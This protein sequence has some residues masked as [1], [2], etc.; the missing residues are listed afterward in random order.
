M[1]KTPKTN[2]A[3]GTSS[4][5]T[6]V[7]K[8]APPQKGSRSANAA[9]LVKAKA[10]IIDA[11]IALNLPKDQVDKVEAHCD[12]M[13]A[14]SDFALL[15]EA[16]A[17]E[18]ATAAKDSDSLTGVFKHILN[19]N[20]SDPAA[21]FD[22]DKANILAVAHALTDDTFSIQEITRM[23]DKKPV[24][25]HGI[26]MAL[27]EAEAIIRD[28]K[29]S[30]EVKIEAQKTL[31]S[32]LDFIRPKNSIM[33]IDVPCPPCFMQKSNLYIDGINA[34]LAKLTQDPEFWWQPVTNASAAELGQAV[35][36]FRE[37]T[38]KGT[39]VDF[40]NIRVKI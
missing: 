22:E 28:D 25:L 21:T 20:T 16:T 26:A 37:Q 15:A 35:K 38:E 31:K 23:C 30:H 40:C 39:G 11:A 8:S 24:Y 34:D 13:I 32:L 9:D 4:K 36:L 5:M 2:T 17:I 29:R 10:I 7:H 19:I 27:A 6:V 18:K 1:A 12:K 14:K 33:H 3:A